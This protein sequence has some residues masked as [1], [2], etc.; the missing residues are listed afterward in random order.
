M[1]NKK[2][3]G[4]GMIMLVIVAIFAL[5]MI[6]WPDMPK[7]VKVLNNLYYISIA[8]ALYMLSWVVF[9]VAQT[10]FFKGMSCL[11]IGVFATNLYIELFL[12]PK[13]WTQW[14]GLLILFVSA[15]LFLSVRLLDKYKKKQ[16]P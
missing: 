4:L 14:D 7:N 12:N 9:I 15:N 8:S 6:Y 10:P 5:S 11:G 13:H 2:D 3:I 16:E 1:S